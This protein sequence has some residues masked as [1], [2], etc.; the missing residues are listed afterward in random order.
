MLLYT[1]IHNTPTGHT[2]GLDTAN[3]GQTKSTLLT[4][5][6]S[7]SSGHHLGAKM[8]RRYAGHEEL[9]AHT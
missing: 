3:Q 5:H 2:V 9:K 6:T 1:H 7:D 4:V 8:K